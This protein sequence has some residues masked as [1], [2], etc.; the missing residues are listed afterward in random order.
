MSIERGK[1]SGEPTPHQPRQPE[2]TQPRQG[3]EAGRA[4]LQGPTTVDG[5]GSAQPPKEGVVDSLVRLFDERATKR[6][7]QYMIEALRQ[8]ENDKLINPLSREGDLRRRDEERRLL[9]TLTPEEQ[10]QY[11]RE[12]KLRTL[13]N[14]R[15]TS[16]QLDSLEYYSPDYVAELR[17]LDP[18]FMDPIIHALRQRPRWQRREK[19]FERLTRLRERQAKKHP[20]GASLNHNSDE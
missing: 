12:Q 19:A 1:P 11:F 3:R 8:M 13:K 2:N 15:N 9:N 7:E 18:E 5:Q 10:I 6:A 14:Y 4:S 20:Q 16:D 17:Q